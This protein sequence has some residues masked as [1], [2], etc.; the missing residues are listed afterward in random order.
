VLHFFSSLFKT[1][2]YTS[3]WDQ[4]DSSLGW[5]HVVSALATWA[6]FTTAVVALNYYV[7]RRE[8]VRNPRAFWIFQSFLLVC[9]TLFLVNAIV[10]WWPTY[11]FRGSWRWRRPF[12]RGRRSSR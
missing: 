4:W 10:L 12:S 6:A 5:L 3:A 9:G 1:T 2:D 8:T 11:R 7:L